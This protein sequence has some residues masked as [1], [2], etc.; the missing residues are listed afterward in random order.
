LFFSSKWKIMKVQNPAALRRTTDRLKTFTW[1]SAPPKRAGAART[2]AFDDVIDRFRASSRVGLYDAL[3]LGVP[4]SM[5]QYVAD[6][7]G[8]SVS[9]VVELIGVPE[10]TFRRKELE[11]EPL[12]DVAGHRLMAYLR[13]IATVQRLLEESGEPDALEHFNTEQWVAR[14]IREPH[15]ELGDRTPAELLRNPEGQ[16]AIEEVLER[17]RGGLPA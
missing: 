13:I 17:M 14:W 5:V 6:A 9:A 10:T 16:R 2:S 7:T 15:P 12:P 11:N 1:P 8:E 3:E 4:T